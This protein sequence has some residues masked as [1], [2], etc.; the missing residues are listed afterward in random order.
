MKIVLFSAKY[1]LVSLLVIALVFL[2]FIKTPLAHD[3]RSGNDCLQSINHYLQT[4]YVAMHD[5]EEAYDT[6]KELA[7][8]Q[9]LQGDLAE[10]SGL[11]Q[12]LLQQAQTMLVQLKSAI[13]HKDLSKADFY[14][15]AYLS[16]LYEVEHAQSKYSGMNLYTMAD[17]N[18][19]QM[20]GERWQQLT[21]QEHLSYILSMKSI[22][23]N[24]GAATSMPSTF[25]VLEQ[26][27]QSS[28]HN[29]ANQTVKTLLHP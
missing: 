22:L 10:A 25:Y 18:H 29:V 1:V 17:L 15:D 12:P 8:L 21:E 16:T 3:E 20:D 19:K 14:V 6:R 26:L 9:Q 11:D 7:K 27:T 2:C 24:Q 28:H 13:Y 23:L 4:S 5:H